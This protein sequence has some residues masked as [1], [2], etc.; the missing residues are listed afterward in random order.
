MS[1]DLISNSYSTTTTLNTL[2]GASN[3]T[4]S[5]VSSLASG[6]NVQGDG[7]D[8]SKGA[9]AMQQLKDLAS[10]DPDKFK[11]VTQQ[12]SDKLSKAAEGASDSNTAKKLSSMAEK[13]A[14]AASSGSMDSLTPPSPPA[15]GNGAQGQ[16]VQQYA[17]QSGDNPMATMDSIV[18]SALSGVGSTEA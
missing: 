16:A 5:S 11:E 3:T 9:K 12:I 10:S 18:S 6:L 14:S 1:T 2:V 4:S 13:F 8:F 17:K 15:G 7:G